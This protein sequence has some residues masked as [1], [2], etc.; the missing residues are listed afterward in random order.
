MLSNETVFVSKTFKH[1]VLTGEEFQGKEFDSCTFTECD[2]SNVVFKSCK[3]I[4]CQFAQCN[5]SNL[6]VSY[7]KFSNIEFE[8]CKMIGIDWTK[9]SWPRFDLNTPFKMYKCL[10]NDCSF[11]GLNMEEL[12]LDECRAH[13]VDF[14]GGNFQFSNF[15]YTDFSQSLFHKTNLKGADFSESINY[16][17]DIFTNEIKDAKFTRIEAVRLLECIGIELVD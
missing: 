12:L 10:I 9:A 7:S 17:I 13:D 5:L 15:S 14:R 8:D 2:F 4:D 3:F 16:D 6:K 1:L 11:Y